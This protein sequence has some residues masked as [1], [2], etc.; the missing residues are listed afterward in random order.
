MRIPPTVEVAP[1]VRAVFPALALERAV[2]A[3]TGG[4]T[5][6]VCSSAGTAAAG[7]P[8]SV[9]VVDHPDGFR[10]MFTHRRCARSQL[11]TGTESRF[12]PELDEA[13]V[14]TGFFISE[15][16][17]GPRALLCMEIAA[18]PLLV[19][20]GGDSI[21][22]AVGL[23]LEDGWT[24]LTGVE[25]E[26]LTVSTLAAS[27]LIHVDTETG[28]VQVIT[29]RGL[30]LEGHAGADWARFAR[31]RREATMLVGQLHLGGGLVATADTITA[32]IHGG[33]V[34]AATLRVRSSRSRR[35]GRR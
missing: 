5:C 15:T 3:A 25:E 33:S 4:F 20:P 2:A 16:T 21:D 28:T 24:L 23:L 29:P 19:T 27:S 34:A 8:V 10:V 11:L 17:A 30:L 13:D 14:H 31:R 35:S 26:I 7:S 32:A 6:P 1:E 18:P 12:S 22:P 9:I